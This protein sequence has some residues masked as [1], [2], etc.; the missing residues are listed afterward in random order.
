MR[1][2]MCLFEWCKF[3]LHISFEKVSGWCECFDSWMEFEIF[4]LTLCSNMSVEIKINLPVL[5]DLNFIFV[6]I[7]Y[8]IV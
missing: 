5:K 6:Y 2:Y 4:Y 3:I 7:K 1:L 8:F